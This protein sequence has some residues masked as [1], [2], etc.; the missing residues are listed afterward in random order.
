MKNIDKKDVGQLEGHSFWGGG[1]QNFI[2]NGPQ[3]VII[4]PWFPPLFLKT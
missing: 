2:S 4:R 3:K 1:G